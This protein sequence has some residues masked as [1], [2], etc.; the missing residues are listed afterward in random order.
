MTRVLAE[1]L[2][3]TGP[4]FHLNLRQLEHGA[5]R[6]S[7]DIRLTTDVLQ[8]VQR[9]L[10]ELGMDPSDTQGQELYALLGARLYEDE[11]RFT[12]AIQANSPKSDDPIAHVAHAIEREVADRQSFSLK[13]TVAKRLLKA[14]IP[15]KTMKALGYRSADSML[16]HESVGSLYAAAILIESD[17][18]LKKQLTAY[19]KL[20]GSDFENRKVSIEHPTSKRWQ[21]LADSVIAK[22]RH[23]IVSFKE[24]GTVVLLPLPQ[25][26]PPLVTLTTAVLTLHAINEIYAASTFLKLHHVQ[27]NFG[28]IAKK[29]ASEE[30]TLTVGLLD[31][32][33]SWQVVQRYFARMSQ[34]IK[35]DL[36]E[37]V[38]HIDDFVWHSVEAV[39]GRIDEGLEFWK[40][41]APLA[42][43][44]GSTATS[45]NLTDQLL[46]HCN[47]LPYESRVFQYFQHELHQELSL[48]Y[49]NHN[50]LEQ[51]LTGQFGRQLSTA[52][53]PVIA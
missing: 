29:V 5:G 22:R 23:N 1:L 12:T 28:V 7:H 36:F 25:E 13:N 40:G 44:H 43:H 53:E 33:L 20:K 24:L 30:L 39:L 19:G 8:G 52:A 9:K 47:R 42:M 10:R 38:L 4:S 27:S 21:A 2:G 26:R 37:P 48:R 17:Q 6:P 51:A 50:R 11:K 15:K 35:T 45:C 31:Q 18:W 14:N 41:T 34:T 49:I 46:S 16:K 3:Q 32:P